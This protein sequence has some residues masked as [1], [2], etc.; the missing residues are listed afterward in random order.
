MFV[1]F[2]PG[3]AGKG[4]IVSALVDRVP[5][6][7]LSRSWTTRPR[8]PGELP[9]AYHFVDEKAFR[10]HAEAGGFLEWVELWP[11]QLSG[12]PIPVSPPGQDILLEIDV[13]GARQVRER[14]P[15]AVL[16][17]V[18]PPS[19]EVQ[20]ARLRGRGDLEERVLARLAL[21]DAEESEGL[22]LADHI[23]VNDDLDRAVEEVAGI[24]KAHRSAQK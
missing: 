18:R 1:V 17:L 6:L 11:G 13:R 19:R 12:T 20:A 8:R 23:V 15:D 14:F 10:A 9:D 7:W 5:D 16:V 3:G 2:G 22:R 24:V 21:S 4:T